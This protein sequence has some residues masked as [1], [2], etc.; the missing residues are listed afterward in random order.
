MCSVCLGSFTNLSVS[1][2]ASTCI[3]KETPYHTSTVTVLYPFD[4]NSNDLSGYATGTLFGTSIPGY[5]T[6][7]YVG[8]QSLALNSAP[9]QQYVQIS[10]VAL[11]QTSFTIET[12]LFLWNPPPMSDLGIFGQCDVSNICLAFSLRNG[13]LVLSF[14]SMNTDNNS[15]VGTSIFPSQTWTHVTVVYD[16]VL[17]QQQIYVNGVIDA[18]SRGLVAAYRGTTT[19]STATIGRTSSFAYTTSYFVG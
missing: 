5:N 9:A 16:T 3:G 17:L 2:C 8:S 14:D 1:A 6:A 11:A 7:C 10:S 19:G 13:R 18:V 15:L 4:G 12:W